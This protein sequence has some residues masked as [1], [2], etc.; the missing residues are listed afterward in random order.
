MASSGF[1][2]ISMAVKLRDI[3]FQIFFA[4]GC[5]L[6][7]VAMAIWRV[8]FERKLEIL[9]HDWLRQVV[10]DIVLA[11]SWVFFLVY[12]WRENINGSEQQWCRI[13]PFCHGVVLF[14]RIC[15]G[16]EFSEFKESY[17]AYFTDLI[18]EA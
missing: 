15:V 17:T 13:L 12:S 1:F 2:L 6:L 9:G 11:L 10:G 18:L 14:R 7:H 4:K 8:Y 16:T 3:E 5:V